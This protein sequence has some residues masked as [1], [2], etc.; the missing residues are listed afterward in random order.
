MVVDTAMVI[1]SGATDTVV[2]IASAAA[3]IIVING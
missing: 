3:V 1:A 2:A